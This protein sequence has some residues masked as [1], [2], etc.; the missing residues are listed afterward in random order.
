MDDVLLVVARDTA[1]NEGGR[2]LESARAMKAAALPWAAMARGD[3]A[4]AATAR[5]SRD[6]K[7]LGRPVTQS[8][9]RT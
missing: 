7:G 5:R 8:R 3:G 4:D 6:P 1:N 2:L 9:G